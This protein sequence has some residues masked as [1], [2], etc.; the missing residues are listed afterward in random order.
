ME[1]EPQGLLL[2]R[3]HV[4]AWLG[5]GADLFARWRERG[6]LNPVY[7]GG[8]RPFYLKTDIRKMLEEASDGGKRTNQEN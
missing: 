6:V 8:K 4:L 3:R 7:V 5:I 2:R 1:G